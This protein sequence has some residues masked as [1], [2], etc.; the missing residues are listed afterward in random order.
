M[1]FFLQPPVFISKYFII[2][3]AYIFL[4]YNILQI[5]CI[6]YFLCV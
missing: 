3:I 5:Y 2:I 6:F 1:L 4:F